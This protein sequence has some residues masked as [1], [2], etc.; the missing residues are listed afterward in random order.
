MMYL[1]YKTES[2]TSNGEVSLTLTKDHGLLQWI[3]NPEKYVS[4][5]NDSNIIDSFEIQT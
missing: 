3:V 5:L 2:I 1:K 4:V